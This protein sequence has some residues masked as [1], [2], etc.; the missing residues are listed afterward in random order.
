MIIDIHIHERTFSGDSKIGLEEIVE[1]AQRKGLDGI[2]ITDHDHNGIA[3]KAFAYREKLGFPIIVGAEIL[4][5]EGDILVFGLDEL[6]NQKMHA[7]ELLRL[8]GNQGGVGIGA[9]PYRDNNRGLGDYIKTLSGLS[10]YEVLN[11]RTEPHNNRRAYEIFQQFDITGFGGSD[12]HRLE[13][14]GICATHFE[15]KIR[16][17]TDFI[18]AVK[19]KRCQPMFYENG[20]YQSVKRRLSNETVSIFN[21]HT[22]LAY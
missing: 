22:H 10:G 8:V 11:G 17:E 20:V 3:E 7:D 4:T 2:C 12:A 15:H 9:H 6:P 14:V 18:E 21:F 5:F 19:S 13:E 1:E 16:H